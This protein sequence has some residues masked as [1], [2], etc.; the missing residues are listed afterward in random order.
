MTR[1]YIEYTERIRVT[2]IPR[3]SH[4]ALVGH[5]MIFELWEE[6]GPHSRC[7]ARRTADEVRGEYHDMKVG[8]CRQVSPDIVIWRVA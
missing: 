6:T 3:N 1:E 2:P 5:Q 4:F 8:E 7:I